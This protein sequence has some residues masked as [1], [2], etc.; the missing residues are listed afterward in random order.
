MYVGVDGCRAGWIAVSASNAGFDYA[1]LSSVQDLCAF[2]RAAKLILVDIP[3]GLP[4]AGCSRRPC[5]AL[6]R[7]V[8][9]RRASSVF[10]APCRS[11]AHAKNIDDA[12]W[13]N[14]KALGMSLSAQAWGI[15]EKIAEVDKFL[16]A[17]P[18][19]RLTVREMHP[20]VCFWGLNG[21]RPM[22][23]SKKTR[24]GI[25]ERVAVIEGIHPDAGALYRRVLAETLRREVQRDDIL[26][27]MVGCVSAMAD[28][29]DEL[30][31][32]SGTPERDEEGLPMEIVYRKVA[33]R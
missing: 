21:G 20:E 12:R 22:Q 5:D 25:A 33:P 32:L 7:K 23:H 18:E 4:G 15:C 10:P 30:M 19:S 13:L 29:T 17:N 27:A 3:I 9:G 6:A 28:G 2:H 31:R 8:L 16:L 24:A 14:I 26:D 1:I 11:A